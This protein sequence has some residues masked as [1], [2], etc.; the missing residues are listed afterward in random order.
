MELCL[1][2]DDGVLKEQERRRVRESPTL[3]ERDETTDETT[4]LEGKSN[5][6][7]EEDLI[8]DQGTGSGVDVD[9]VKEASPDWGDDG[10]KHFEGR[11]WEIR[12]KISVQ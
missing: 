9:G 3:Q 2:G 6:S 7:S 10:P 4:H 12:R 1:D 5:S 8:P 11:R